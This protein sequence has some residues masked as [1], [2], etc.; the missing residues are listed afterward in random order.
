MVEATFTLEVPTF[1]LQAEAG[2]MPAAY[3]GAVASVVSMVGGAGAASSAVPLI[4]GGLDGAVVA[5]FSAGLHPLKDHGLEITGGYTF[6]SVDGS[7]NVAD[8]LP[9]LGVAPPPSAAGSVVTL[10]STLH[11]VKASIRW[12][13]VVADH[14]VLRTSVGYLQ[15]LSS[16]SRVE[17]TGPAAADPTVA[18]YVASANPTVDK[19]LND[20]FTRYVKAPFASVSLGAR[21]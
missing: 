21:L 5:G 12:R 19:T 9:A 16:S 20:A 2:V 10:H 1:L 14:F 15:T 18:A 8:A 4:Q 17:L 3:V 11:N 7:A 13:W 6:I